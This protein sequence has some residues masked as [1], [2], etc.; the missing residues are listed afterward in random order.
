M[1]VKNGS[2]KSEDA[3]T[4][5]R[6]GSKPIGRNPKKKKKVRRSLGPAK[7]QVRRIQPPRGRKRK[8][9]KQS[10]TWLPGTTKEKGTNYL[11]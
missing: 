4:D 9:K 1:G 6:G 8:R 2:A 11:I 5:R 7:V 3:S 10:M